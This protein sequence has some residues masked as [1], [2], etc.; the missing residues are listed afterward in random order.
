MPWGVPAAR[1]VGFTQRWSPRADW[2]RHACRRAGRTATSGSASRQAPDRHQPRQG[3]WASNLRPDADSAASTYGAPNR[4]NRSRCWATMLARGLVAQ[5][6]RKLAALS[7]QGR[8]DLGGDPIHA[9]GAG[10]WPTSSWP[11]TRRSRSASWSELDTRGQSTL[12]PVGRPGA[13]GSP[14]RIKPPTVGQLCG[15]ERAVAQRRTTGG[16][17][18][19]N[20]LVGSPLLQVHARVISSSTTERHRA[21]ARHRLPPSGCLWRASLCCVPEEADCDAARLWRGQ[22]GAA[23]LAGC[24]P[25][26][27][28]RGGSAD[29]PALPRGAGSRRPRTVDAQAG[30]GS[31]GRVGV[32]EPA[33]SG[34][35]SGAGLRHQVEDGSP[36][37]TGSKGRTGFP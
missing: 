29:R 28:Y 17:H 12:E 30:A 20:T 9:A 34:T 25:H 13:A 31:W 24:C 21:L 1:A 32:L 15:R 7:E 8:P 4:A 37:L 35:G 22:L 26:R 6:G 11:A 14:I 19:G 16:S 18:V 36:G 5:Q 23:G 10:R 2:L 3:P 27:S 33:S